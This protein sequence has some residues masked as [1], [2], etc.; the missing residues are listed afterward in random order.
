MMIPETVSVST[1]ITNNDMIIMAISLLYMIN[2]TFYSTIFNTICSFLYIISIY[3]FIH[4]S[5]PKD[6]S[7][8]KLIIQII[9]F[10]LICG[11][12]LIA[13]RIKLDGKEKYNKLYELLKVYNLIIFSFVSFILKIYYISV[14]IKLV[15]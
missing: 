2:S 7:T 10:I 12:S 5:N 11:S 3:T 8:T 14:C 9:L 1:N 13:I 4:T 15:P 6:N